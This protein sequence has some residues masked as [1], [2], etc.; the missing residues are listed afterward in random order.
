MRVAVE[1]R[2]KLVELLR[3]LLDLYH[4]AQTAAV[5]D[6]PLG[7]DL[8]RRVSD[9][10]IDLPVHYLRRGVS[11]FEVDFIDFL[12]KDDHRHRCPEKRHDDVAADRRKQHDALPALLVG[13]QVHAHERRTLVERGAVHRAGVL[14]HRI[15]RADLAVRFCACRRH[16]PDCFLYRHSATLAPRVISCRKPL[17]EYF[18]TFFCT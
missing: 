8:C 9:G 4:A 17:G 16:F 10:N 1:R 2:D 11:D 3:E 15:D 5:D 12:R 13:L 14:V 6:N 7:T 18:I